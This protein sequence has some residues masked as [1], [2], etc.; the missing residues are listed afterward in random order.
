[1]LAIQGGVLV[2]TNTDTGWDVGVH[3]RLCTSMYCHMRNVFT[4][5]TGHVSAAE[6]GGLLMIGVT[7]YQI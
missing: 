5:G 1:M 3:E 2:S 4:V 6:S 7:T